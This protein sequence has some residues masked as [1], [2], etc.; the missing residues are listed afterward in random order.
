MIYLMCVC[1]GVLCVVCGVYGDNGFNFLGMFSTS[2]SSEADRTFFGILDLG[3]VEL[4]LEDDGRTSKEEGVGVGVAFSIDSDLFG[5]LAI[6]SF[7][8]E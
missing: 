1:V 6:L 2:A 5:E 4:E 8:A 7:L 3:V